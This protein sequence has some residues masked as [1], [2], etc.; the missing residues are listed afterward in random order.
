M[1]SMEQELLSVL[2]YC[3][4]FKLLPHMYLKLLADLVSFRTI[5]PEGYDAIDYCAGFLEK[6]G[7]RCHKLNFGEVSNLYARYGNFEKNICFAGHIDVVPPMDGWD[8]DPFVLTERD[9]KLYG[10]GT[11]DM[12]GPL[13]SALSAIATFLQEHDPNF[14]ISVLL[15]SDE[16]IMGDNGTNKVVEWLSAR[17]EN[18]TGCVLCESCS[19]EKSGEYIK[20]GCRGSLNVDL[21]STGTQ[22]HVVNGQKYGNH[23]ND[24]MAFLSIFCDTSLDDGNKRFS[25]SD[26]EMT[27]IDVGN[28]TRNVIP[29]KATA[30]FNIRF[31]DNWTFDALENFIATMLPKNISVHFQRFSA[32]FIGANDNFIEFCS[33]AIT[34]AIGI[35]PK[36]GTYGGNSDAVSLHR[37]TNVVEIGTPISNAHIVNEWCSIDELRTLKRIYYTI[38]DSFA[39]ISESF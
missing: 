2:K 32:P 36:N 24:F 15:T 17:N 27:S 20:I 23:L 4:N 29:S 13:S 1:S 31:N 39:T 14:S 30:K 19:P 18:L 8:T 7:F 37:I 6:L 3:K 12:K 26:I 33:S 5:T 25:P 11:N 21:I 16:E 28:D 22:C 35:M 10:R 34:K 38:I 9:G